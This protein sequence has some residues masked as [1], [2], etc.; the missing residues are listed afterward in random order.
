MSE[1]TLLVVVVLSIA[2]FILMVIGVVRELHFHRTVQQF[3]NGISSLPPTLD[4]LESAITSLNSE[5][6]RLS[7]D[8]HD[9]HRDLREQVSEAKRLTLDVESRVSGLIRD[10]HSRAGVHVHQSNVG[11]NKGQ[12]NQGGSVEANG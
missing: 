11:T 7:S 6:E 1:A 2:V 10:F 12:T 3:G 4:K 5:L 8:T 9:R